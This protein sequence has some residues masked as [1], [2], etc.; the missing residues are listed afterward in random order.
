MMAG[1]T[2]LEPA[3]S[4]VTEYPTPLALMRTHEQKLLYR[5]EKSMDYFSSRIS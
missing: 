3:A 5:K 4:A 1:T 2:G